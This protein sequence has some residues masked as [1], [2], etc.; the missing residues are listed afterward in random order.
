MNSSNSH[1]GL[2][3]VEEQNYEV[4]IKK[5]NFLSIV[6]SSPE[7]IVIYLGCSGE[8]AMIIYSPL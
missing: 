3:E 4:E 8:K 6:N 7:A 5:V 2:L 1:D